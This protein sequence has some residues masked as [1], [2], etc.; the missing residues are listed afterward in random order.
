M[1]LS[2]VRHASSF[3][4]N[5]VWKMMHLSHIFV[6]KMMHPSSLERCH[7]FHIECEMPHAFHTNVKHLVPFIVWKIQH[8]SYNNEIHNVFHSMRDAMCFI[9]ERSHILH[10]LETSRILQINEIQ[11]QID[12]CSISLKY[13]FYRFLSCLY[14]IRHFHLC[15]AIIHGHVLPTDFCLVS[16]Q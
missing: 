13:F 5:F 4:K 3:T 8:V 16:S 6:W 15:I 11:N 9:I 7:A 1:H 10:N 2:H 14:Y 12:F